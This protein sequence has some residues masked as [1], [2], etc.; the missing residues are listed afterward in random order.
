MDIGQRRIASPPV[1]K[2][3]IVVLVYRFVVCLPINSGGEG[4]IAF[5]AIGK[6]LLLFCRLFFFWVNSLVQISKAGKRYK[7]NIAKTSGCGYNQV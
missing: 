3:Y 6:K 4:R 2:K 7:K 5:G 1:G